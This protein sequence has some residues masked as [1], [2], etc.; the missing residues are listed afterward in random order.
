MGRAGGTGMGSERLGLR[1]AAL[2]IPHCRQNHM[3]EWYTNTYSPGCSQMA[4]L[5]PEDMEIPNER[6]SKEFQKK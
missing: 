3:G 5:M 2:H 1:G 4:N 6:C